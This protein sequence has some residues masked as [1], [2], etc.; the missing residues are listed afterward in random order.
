M[1]SH[2]AT[3]PPLKP[4]RSGWQ[5]IH[6]RLVRESRSPSI[7]TCSISSP[8]MARESPSKVTDQNEFETAI[9]KMRAEMKAEMEAG[10]NTRV[11][12]GVAQALKNM[13]IEP[14][15]SSHPAP[16]D[17]GKKPMRY[18]IDP[19]LRHQDP[20]LYQ[21]LL[22]EGMVPA[23]ENDLDEVVGTRGNDRAESAVRKTKEQ[24]EEKEFKTEKETSDEISKL[25]KQLD[26]MKTF[27][28]V[29]GLSEFL[30]DSDDE[31]LNLKKATPV[32]YKMPKFSL[33]NG[34]GS[35]RIHLMQYKSLMEISGSPPEDIVKMFPLSLTGAAQTWYYNLDKKQTR[36]WNELSALFLREYAF[37]AEMDVGMRDLEC[38]AQ[39]T[40]EPFAE[41]L[42]RWRSK[43]SQMKRRPDAEDQ[44]KLFIKGT[45]P[46]YRSKMYYMPLE[47]FA[48]VYKV[49]LSIE[50]QVNE[51][52]RYAQKFRS[53]GYQGNG[54]K[55]AGLG[56]KP[57]V[58]EMGI[59]V[60]KAPRK[61]SKLSLP[62]SKVLKKLQSR[63]LLQPLDPRPPPNPLPSNFNH[64][65]YCE[66]HQTQG[67]DTDKCIRLRHEIQNLIEEGK[68]PDPEKD[69]PNVMTNPLPNFHNVPPA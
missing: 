7:S 67:H 6:G 69:K 63:G 23:L 38:T 68:I 49:G 18:Q 31:D 30:D 32:A 5:R 8:E 33:Y 40:D 19:E 45:L 20:E 22:N 11:Q 2:I 48:Q 34:M 44:I 37:N 53:A 9:R 58:S 57:V 54:N 46:Q 65:A 27:M 25:S 24:S 36:D 42:M 60:V 62:M 13:N 47:S 66:F 28:K 14:A 12:E 15:Q 3:I 51:E 16:K 21:Q 39:K 10:F 17:K 55:T 26:K 56:S 29:K 61:F 59:V 43:L 4:R 1:C 52:K 50:D 35:P 41:Y 64:N